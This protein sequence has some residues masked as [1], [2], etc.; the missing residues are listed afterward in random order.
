M[1]TGM[2]TQITVVV[3][4]LFTMLNSF[5]PDLLS[6]EVQ[7]SILTLILFVAGYFFADKVQKGNDQRDE[8]LNGK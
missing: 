1:K 3:G 4:A 5:M 2:R 7:T 8:I 6:A